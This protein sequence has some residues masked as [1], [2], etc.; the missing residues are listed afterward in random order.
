MDK[1]IKNN[2]GCFISKKVPYK[3]I[4]E[5]PLRIL[6]KCFDF[7]YDMTYGNKGEHRSYRSGGKII[8]KNG[9]V[10]INTFQGKLAEYGIWNEFENRSFDI[11]SPDLSEYNLGKWDDFDIKYKDYN[12]AVK[13]TKFYGNLLLLEKDDWNEHGIYIPNED[14][15]TGYYDFFVLI[16]I[17]P[18]GEYIM[19][20]KRKLYSSE[21]IDREDLR[22]IIINNSNKW[23][24][25][26][27]GFITHEDLC[28]IIKN[29]DIIE[30]GKMLNGKTPMD[31]NNYYVQAGCMRNINAMF[32]QFESIKVK[33]I[34]ESGNKKADELKL[35]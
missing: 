5:F 32:S 11:N 12:I 21:K 2:N 27:P 4:K 9:E 16:R 8:R 24:D 33:E 18:D 10:F 25:D 3:K 23:S 15:G 30:A 1:L 13:S 29:K 6:N 28:S 31:T 26:V 35:E 19:K 17:S 20:E 14:K 22:K 34:D 7:A